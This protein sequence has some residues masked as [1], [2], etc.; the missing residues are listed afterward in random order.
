MHAWRDTGDFERQRGKRSDEMHQRVLLAAACALLAG[1][2]AAQTAP[3]LPAPTMG[4]IAVRLQP[5]GALVGT[6]G[7]IDPSSLE[8]VPL[9]GVTVSFIQNGRL[10]ARA[11]SGAEGDLVVR[12][13]AAQA[14]YSVIGRAMYDGRNW[15][16]AHAVTV[17]APE[18]G[19]ASAALSRRP[20]YRL[21]A[22]RA[23][24]SK[25][26]QNAA[27][28]IGLAMV[29]ESD[30]GLDSSDTSAPVLG[31]G[32][33]AHGGGGGGHGGL[34]G[35]GWAAAALAAAV[36]I[37]AADDDNFVLATPFRP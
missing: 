9:P 23:V 34:G 32:F 6:V 27:P 14:V 29:P 3:Q 8:L 31:D 19:D 36:A 15:F 26:E 17:L 24:K 25:L 4:S 12:G 16:L 13:L 7:H 37:A 5:D 1:S 11:L 33:V 18:G 30:L 22:A 21:T 10:V 28:S 20:V 2:A 35:G